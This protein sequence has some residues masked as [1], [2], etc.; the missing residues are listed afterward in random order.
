MFGEQIERA[1]QFVPIEQF[2]IIVYDDFVNST[3]QVYENVLSF[4]NLP[5]DGRTDFPIIHETRNY[6]SLKVA[7]NLMYPPLPVKG[8]FK[9]LRLLRVKKQV[10]RM[11]MSWNEVPGY[12]QQIRP[13]F[14]EELVEVFRSDVEK[15]ERIL[16]RDLSYWLCQ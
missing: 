9:A 7:R 6:R 13:E 2:K 14:R 11:I 4:L 8:L 15:L 5:L 10:K 3:R 12:G 1:L 16:N